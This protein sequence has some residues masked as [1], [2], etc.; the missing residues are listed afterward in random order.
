MLNAIDAVD[1][2]AL[3]GPALRYEPDRAA[4]GLRALATATGL[5]Q[6]ADAGSFL[7][8]GGL[9]HDHS[10]EVFPAAVTAVPLLLAIVRHGHPAAGATALGLL[11]DALAF[12]THDASTRV[13]TPYA[14][15]VPICCALADRVRGGAGLLAASGAEGGRLLADADGHW[16]FDVEEAVAEGDGALAFGALAGRWPGGGTSVRR[17]FTAP[18][19]PYPSYRPCSTIRPR[20][21]TPTP[22]CASPP[23]SRRTAPAR[24]PVPGPVCPG[25]PA[26][27]VL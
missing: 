25:G 5:V 1:W 14:E 10:G 12:A 13:A 8:G 18:A 27:V 26:A 19:A 11:D 23:C 2:S 16:R 17:S 24:R 7:A 6:A 9:V 3:P 21:A 22:A 4:A 15:A 20:T